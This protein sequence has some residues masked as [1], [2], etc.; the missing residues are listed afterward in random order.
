MAVAAVVVQHGSHC[1]P[2]KLRHLPLKVTN[3]TAGTLSPPPLHI[4]TNPADVN[5]RHLQDLYALCNHSGHRFPSF[6]SNG[7]VEPVDITKLRTALTHSSVLVSVF[8]RPEFTSHSSSTTEASKSQGTGGEWIWRVMPITPANGQ[9]VGFGRAVSDLELTATIYDVMVTPSLRGRGIG[10][11]IVQ[12]IVRMLTNQ[13]VN[14]ISALCSDKDRLF[15]RAC[16]FGDDILCST[17]MMY[18][19]TASSFLQGDQMVISAGRKLLLVP[20]MR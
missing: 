3:Q 6:D 4:S 19:R 2:A 18:T 8:A 10:R 20:P 7:R 9:L 13:G 16:G 14:D 11:R 15:F 12:R 1:L 5:P 17:T